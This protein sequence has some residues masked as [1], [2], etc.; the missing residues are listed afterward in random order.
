MQAFYFNLHFFRRD[1]PLRD[2]WDV[3]VVKIHGSQCNPRSGRDP[4]KDYLLLLLF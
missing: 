2:L 3:L 1:D 4:F